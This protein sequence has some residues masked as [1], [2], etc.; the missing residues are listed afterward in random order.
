MGLQFEH[1]LKLELDC[2][3]LTPNGV[4]LLVFEGYLPHKTF[5]KDVNSELLNLGVRPVQV[6][7]RDGPDIGLGRNG[8]PQQWRPAIGGM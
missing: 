6:S 1:G 4:R 7:K 5:V 8:Q 2:I 3:E